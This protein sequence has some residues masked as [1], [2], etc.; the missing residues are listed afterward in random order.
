MLIN[1]YIIVLNLADTDT[2]PNT[3]QWKAGTYGNQLNK[4]RRILTF[5]LADL[6][7]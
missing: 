5:S 6:I 2:D 4:K 3:E 1:E 7:N